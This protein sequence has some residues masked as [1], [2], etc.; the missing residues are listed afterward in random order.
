MGFNIFV[1]LLRVRSF[2]LWGFR[3]FVFGVRGSGKRLGFRSCG[4]WDFGGVPG[5]GSFRF[6]AQGLNVGDSVFR[7]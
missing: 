7:I 4:V 3:S 2:G 5:F 1:L 6:R